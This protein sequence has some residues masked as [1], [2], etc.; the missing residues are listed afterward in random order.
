VMTHTL[1]GGPSSRLFRTLRGDHGLCYRVSAE[2]EHFEDTGL[3][4]IS[5]TTRPQDACRAVQLCA[6]ELH[7]VATEPVGEEELEA[8][9]AAMVGR[10]LRRTETARGSAH[11]YATRWRA[12]RMETPDERADAIRAVTAEDV[13]VVAQRIRSSL[14]DARLALVGPE[15]QGESLLATVT[16][17]A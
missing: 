11:W 2:H 7:R 8:A 12:G 14:G 13:Q 6:T 9:R 3:F 4:V 17:A 5:T 15:D 10:L 1:G 16:A